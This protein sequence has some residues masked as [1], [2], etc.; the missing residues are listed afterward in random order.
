MDAVVCAT[1]DHWHA[2]VSIDA[3]NSGKHIYVEKPMSRYLGEA[4]EVHDTVKRTG[5][6]FQV[7]F[8]RLLGYE[9]AQGRRMDP[10][11]KIGPV[12]MSQGSYMRNTP[13]VNGTNTR[14]K[15]GARRR[16]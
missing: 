7:G 14:S 6:I 8:A 2:R 9:V 11:G 10:A 15:L 16:T 13:P 1:V 12:V 3:L 4:F 5:K